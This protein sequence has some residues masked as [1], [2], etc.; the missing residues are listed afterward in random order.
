MFSEEKQGRK[1]AGSAT[2]KI[3]Q[4]EIVLPFKVSLFIQFIQSF[5]E[6]RECI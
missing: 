3:N 4:Y 1:V 6:W 5:R 2:H